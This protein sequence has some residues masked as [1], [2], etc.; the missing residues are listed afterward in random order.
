[1]AILLF[2][3]LL[4]LT[5]VIEGVAIFLLYHRKDYLYYSCLCNLLTN[6]ALNAILA[7]AVAIYGEVVYYP[8]LICTEVA[9]LFIE[10]YVYR[11][12]GD[13]KLASSIMLSAFLNSLSFGIG[14]LINYLI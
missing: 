1:M 6:P 9:V 7:V 8:A 12:L 3:G 14:L 11:Y 10:A 4:L 2:T 5:I 13:F